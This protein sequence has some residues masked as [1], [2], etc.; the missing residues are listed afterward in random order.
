[1][2]KV[3]K[4]FDYFVIAIF[5]ISCVTAGALIQSGLAF[6]ENHGYQQGQASMMDVM[7]IE[8]ITEIKVK[9]L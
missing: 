8:Q 5:L 4:I 6:A 7:T 1:M 2:V 9:D 3:K